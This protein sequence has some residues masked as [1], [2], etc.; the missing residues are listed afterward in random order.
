VRRPA[1]TAAIGAYE[2]AI[3]VTNGIDIRVKYLAQI[4]ATSLIGC[5]L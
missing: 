1:I 3:L 4:K 2:A 5:A